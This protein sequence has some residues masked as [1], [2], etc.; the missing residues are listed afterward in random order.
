M[1]S[2]YDSS[3]G[4]SSPA[5]ISCQQLNAKFLFEPSKSPTDDRLGNPEPARSV[6]HSPGID[7]FYECL[8]IFDIQF[9]VPDFATESCRRRG[10]RIVSERDKVYP[11]GAVA[12]FSFRNCQSQKDSNDLS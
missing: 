9:D 5:G 2:K 10:Y 11:G 3:F 12:A 4:R 1:I 7:N 8:Q 6:R